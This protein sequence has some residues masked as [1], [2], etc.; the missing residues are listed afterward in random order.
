M[1]ISQLTQIWD[2]WGI[3]RR[4]S[5]DRTRITIAMPKGG[6]IDAPNAGFSLGQSV[7]FAINQF[8]KEVVSVVPREVAEVKRLLAMEP[9]LE[10]AI[11]SPEPIPEENPIPREITIEDMLE[12]LDD[13][14]NDDGD[15]QETS[16]IDDCGGGEDR[17]LIEDWEDLTGYSAEEE[18]GL[19][20]ED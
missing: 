9:L 6:T 4:V 5:P 11:A 3:V 7:A 16:C 10:L 19:G 17:E 14:Y 15:R 2:N 8:T 12:V 18:L 1:T 13:S 20:F